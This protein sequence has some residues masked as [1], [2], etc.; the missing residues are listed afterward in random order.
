[1]DSSAAFEEHR[2]GHG[3]HIELATAVMAGTPLHLEGS[4]GG[5]VAGFSAND[6]KLKLAEPSDAL[7]EP[8]FNII[9]RGWWA[10]EMVSLGGGARIWRNIHQDW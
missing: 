4:L 5:A 3:G 10:H 8:D 9:C 7:T 2:E 1:M 6:A